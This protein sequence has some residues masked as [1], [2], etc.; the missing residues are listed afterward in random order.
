LAGK[1]EGVVELSRCAEGLTYEVMA[2]RG[3]QIVGQTR[4]YVVATLRSGRQPYLVRV[5]SPDGAVS[6]DFKPSDTDS[7]EVMRFE[8]GEGWRRVGCA[9]RTDDPVRTLA[10]VEREV[11]RVVQEIRTKRQVESRKREGILA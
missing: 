9:E 10:N 5:S 1:R 6:S 8:P 3:A 4:R 7:V 11:T 2:R